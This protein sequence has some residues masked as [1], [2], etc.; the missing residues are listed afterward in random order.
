MSAI[1]E[2]AL[3]A[4]YFRPLATDPAALEL[5]DDA[6]IL[7]PPPGCD[8]V[9]TKDGI[10]EGIHFLPGEEGATVARKA[11]RVNLSDLA[12]MGAEPLGY[13]VLLG[14]PDNWTEDWV[15]SFAAGLAADQSAFC[16]ALYGGDTIRAPATTV[17]ITALGTV[18]EGGAVKRSGARAGD[19]LF[20]SGTIGDG[21]LG[22]L[23]ARGELDG[24]APAARDW[25]AGRYR[26][27]E[28]RC[29]LAAIVRRLA[30]AAIDVS[31]G[32]V[33]DLD[34]LCTASGVSAR[35]EV[36]RVPLSPGAGAAVSADASMFDLCLTG[37]DDYEILAAIPSQSAEEYARAAEDVGVPVAR[38]GEVVAGA[39]PAQFV[40][41]TG[42]QRAFARRSFSHTS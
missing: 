6:A 40:D 13:L 11:L 35:V 17:S 8:L 24:L 21:G 22:L 20:V 34:K 16:V 33:G 9:L 36:D 15:A 4:R 30:R 42:S 7:R 41:A 1:D 12:A 10:V 2:H 23:A 27:P 14:L 31:D 3:I 39:A 37:G 29:A 19:A 38:I 28:P 18:P 5:V 25:L 32:L 26:C